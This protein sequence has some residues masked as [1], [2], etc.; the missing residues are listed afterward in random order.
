MNKTTITVQDWIDAL[1]SGKYGQ[2]KGKLYNGKNYCCLG[3][4]CQVGGATFRGDDRHIV[5]IGKD[6]SEYSSHDLLDG[7]TSTDL[8]SAVRKVQTKKEF[9]ITSKKS[10]IEVT[11][12]LLPD[13]DVKGHTADCVLS[14]FVDLND[15]HGAS[16]KEIAQV[17]RNILRPSAKLRVWTN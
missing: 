2:T 9:S 13:G 16:F 11:Y 8:A 4:L 15:E 14:L 5:Y 12:A 7:V 1:E 10:G 6:G 3:V 17:A